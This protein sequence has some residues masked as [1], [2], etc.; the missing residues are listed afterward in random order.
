M[1]CAIRYP[2]LFIFL[3]ECIIIKFPMPHF[4][5]QTTT[6]LENKGKRKE[7]K[8]LGW[9]CFTQPMLAPKS[10]T[11][12]FVF[13]F[14][15]SILFSVL[16]FKGQDLPALVLLSHPCFGQRGRSLIAWCLYLY[17][18]L[19]LCLCLCFH[20]DKKRGVSTVI[21]LVSSDMFVGWEVGGHAHTH[22]HAHSHTKTARVWVG[23]QCKKKKKKLVDGAKRTGGQ[24]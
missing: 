15:F 23:D 24:D 21:L 18:C 3:D 6:H 11:R 8:T 20:P 5:S 9:Y 7:K 16:S 2:N 13:G 14:L 17:L 10:K 22:S 1:W 4:S 19:C 12:T